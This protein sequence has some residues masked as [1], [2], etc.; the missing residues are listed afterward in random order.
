[1]MLKLL[2]WCFASKTGFPLLRRWSAS[3]YCNNIIVPQGRIPNNR[4]VCLCS[5]CK[6]YPEG[7]FLIKST[8][9]DTLPPE[10]K[11][12]AWSNKLPFPCKDCISLLGKYLPSH[13]LCLPDCQCLQTR[14]SYLI[15]NMEFCCPVL[16][17]SSTFYMHFNSSKGLW[18]ERQIR[19]MI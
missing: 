1:M 15:D 17:F 9:I 4:A 10:G 8:Y 3:N 11:Q 13:L 5:P 16:G 19:A 12:N 18:E 6:R 7:R 14:V 2:W